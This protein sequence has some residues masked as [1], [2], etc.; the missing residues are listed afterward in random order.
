MLEARVVLSSEM[1]RDKIH[2]PPA[3]FMPPPGLEHCGV[4][5]S[6]TMRP[7]TSQGGAETAFARKV[8]RR[9]MSR[10]MQWSP[11]DQNAG[12]NTEESTAISPTAFVDLGGASIYYFQ[13]LAPTS[14]LTN[15]AN[16]RLDLVDRALSSTHILRQLPSPKVHYAG[17]RWLDTHRVEYT[18]RRT[19]QGFVKLTVQC[20]SLVHPASDI[21]LEPLQNSTATLAW[22]GPT[23]DAPS[24]VVTPG[25]PD[26]SPLKVPQGWYAQR[27]TSG[28]PAGIITTRT[29]NFSSFHPSLHL[30]AHA[31]HIPRLA[32]ADC[33]IDVLAVL[34][35]TYFFDPYELHEQRAKLGEDHRHYGPVE[36]EKPAEAVSSWGSVLHLWQ[37]PH[38]TDLDLVVPIHAR[39]RLPPVLERTVGYAGE[40]GGSTHVDTALLPPIA[41][42]MCPAAE[43]PRFQSGNA[44]LDKLVVRLAL[45]DELDLAAFSVLETSPDTDTLVRMPVGDATHASLIRTATLVA[46]T[47]GAAFV[48]WFVRNLLN[49]SQPSA[50]SVE[51]RA[52]DK[53]SKRD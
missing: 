18:L 9:W 21:S 8:M 3:P 42:V 38:L 19:P 22:I 32:S 43:F 49:Q 35:P 33:R 4:H 6:A 23:H 30:V 13:S 27:D 47:L 37:H 7:E 39:Y 36:L 31:D 52:V 28:Q 25:A 29:R 12:E 2:L 53:G 50:V 15:Q 44:I 45:L 26:R 14:L 20:L 5:V 51:K 41:A 16:S 46:F 40:P 11:A 1:C 34:P 10:F 17:R 48:V 24:F